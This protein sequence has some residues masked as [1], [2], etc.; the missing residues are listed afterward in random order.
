[1]K[2][3]DA[4]ARDYFKKFLVRTRVLREFLKAEDYSDV[5]REG[6]EALELFIKGLLRSMSIQPDF[7]HDPGKQ[8][9]EFAGDIPD[10]FKADARQLIEWSKKLRKERELAFYGAED[11]I[12][13]DEYEKKDAEAVIQF[14]EGIAEKVGKACSG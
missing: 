7:S 8:L 4:L 5:I 2:I 1:M 14:L 9:S 6:Q 11:F 3:H 10:E 13:G 12:P